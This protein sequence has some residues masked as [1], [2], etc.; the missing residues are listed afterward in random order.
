MRQLDVLDIP[1]TAPGKPSKAVCTLCWRPFEEDAKAFKEHTEQHLDE[2]RTSNSCQ[3]CTA[4]FLFRADL[5]CHLK[6]PGNGRCAFPFNDSCID[7]DRDSSLQGSSQD[8]VSCRI[9]QRFHRYVVLLHWERLQIKAALESIESIRSIRPVMNS[10]SRAISCPPCARNRTVYSN[11]KRDPFL[12]Q[13]NL[14]ILEASGSTTDHPIPSNQ[15]I[16]SEAT[17]I[18]CGQGTY[19]QSGSEANRSDEV[20]LLF[21]LSPSIKIRDSMEPAE[22][23]AAI[24]DLKKRVQRMMLLIQP[25]THV[26]P[27]LQTPSDPATPS[28]FDAEG[29]AVRRLEVHQHPSCGAV[30]SYPRRRNAP[31]RLRTRSQSLSL[32]LSTTLAAD[33]IRARHSSE[34]PISRGFGLQNYTLGDIRSC[35][36]ESSTASQNA[37]PGEGSSQKSS[38][39]AK[40]QHDGG[41]ANGAEKGSDTGAGEDDGDRGGDGGPNRKRQRTE[42]EGDMRKYSCIFYANEP[43]RYSKHTT[44]FK[45]I[46]ALM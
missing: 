25:V 16:P 32:G 15:E 45:Y 6:V 43:Q 14:T 22:V 4:N 33:N 7:D 41:S 42:T 36:G 18:D 13:Q 34:P 28:S 5:D 1:Y 3:S 24:Q 10:G 21:E 11:D 35:T 26:S 37:V 27:S 12:D 39:G 20:G 40:R 46:S 23:Y 9:D 19:R 8:A 44:E 30:D 2:L 38:G 17:G 31:G 29:N